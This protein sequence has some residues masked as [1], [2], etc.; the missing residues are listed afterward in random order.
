MKKLTTITLFLAICLSSCTHYYYVSN[1]QN[2][3]LFR[4]KNEYR[5]SATI[6]EGDESTCIEAQAAYS[7][8]DKIGVMTNFMSAKGG[9]V[10]D[11]DYGKG[12]YI[13]GAIGYYKPIGKI[14]VFEIYGGIGGSNQH[15]QY[16][17]NSTSDLSFAK[18]FIQPSFGLTFKLFDIGVSTRLGSLSYNKI[19]NHIDSQLNKLEYD[20]L[21][22]IARQSNYLFL[23]PAIT[24]RGGWKYAKVQIQASPASFINKTQLHSEDYHFTIGIYIAIAERFK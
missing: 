23:E 8:T 20:K 12:T 19:E 21:N 1:T 17:S 4:E 3:P 9:A 18:F 24:V 15:H 10:S 22:I 14:G 5:L 11:K 6:G 16:S 13:D 7:L 2:M